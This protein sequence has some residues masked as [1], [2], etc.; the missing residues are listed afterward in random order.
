MLGCSHQCSAAAPVE[1]TVTHGTLKTITTVC[2]IMIHN[3][4]TIAITT[5]DKTCVGSIFAVKGPLTLKANVK[6]LVGRRVL[7]KAKLDFLQHQRPS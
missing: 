6:D 3:L 4:T 5:I 7:P 2:I 1:V